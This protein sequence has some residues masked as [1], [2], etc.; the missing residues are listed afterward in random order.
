GSVATHAIERALQAAAD[1]Q[2]EVFR[3]SDNRGEGERSNAAGAEF[4]SRLS[5][6]SKAISTLSP[7]SRS[8]LNRLVVAHIKEY[9]DTETLNALVQ[10]IGEIA[11]QLAPE[12]RAG[13]VYD[14]IY[15]PI[16]GVRR[17][18]PS[19]LI[20]LWS[21]LPAETRMAVEK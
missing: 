19:E 11:P 17:T 20:D 18:A 13:E 12:R 2:L 7:A 5:R 6:L 21:M 14:A 10:A 4:A 3:R 15:R 1:H 8:A 9:F 16:Q